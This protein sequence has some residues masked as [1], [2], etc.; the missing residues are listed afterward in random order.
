MKMKIFYLIYIFFLCL[1]F[2][3]VNHYYPWTTYDS[4]K[5]IFYVFLLI[6]FY[7]FIFNKKNIKINTNI[8]F[9]VI[10]F[11]FSISSYH[12][13]IFKQYYYVFNLYIVNLIV[14]SVILT[15]Y[16]NKKLKLLEVTVISLIISGLISSIF[17]I[18]QWIDFAKDAIWLYESDKS[19]LTAN[20]AQPNH[21]ATLLLLSLLSCLYVYERFKEN[22][23]LF[24]MPVIIF[25][26]VLT[27]SRAAFLTLIL[28]LFFCILKWRK[29]NNN[30]KLILISY[31]PIYI[32]VSYFLI[33]INEKKYIINRLNGG[34][35]RL[36]IWRDFFSVFSYIDIWGIG[37]KNI[38]YFQFQYGNHFSGYLSSYHN[39]LLDLIVIFGII[40]VLFFLYIFIQLIIILFKINKN[41]D[42][43][44]FLMLYTLINHSLLEFPLFYNYFLFVFCILYFYLNNAYLLDGIYIKINKNIFLL[45]VFLITTF[46]FSFIYFFEKERVN[47]RALFLGY[48]VNDIK[49]NIFF[50]EFYNLKIINC[51]ENIYKENL[52]KF[53]AGLLHRPSE[54][55]ILKLIYIY[56]KVEEYEKRNNLLIKYNYRYKKNYTVNEILK[57]KF[58]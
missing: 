31:L 17:S 45:I 23:V 2:L 52:S 25:S 6:I 42:F 50:D 11:I 22:M 43:I 1:A 41:D 7:F 49:N 35:E 14:L 19:R 58:Y 36:D 4:E 38:E 10:L 20:M 29:L 56:H 51:K 53:E 28:I 3:N 13:Y 21:L 24:L 18:Y 26:L 32:L 9:L 40:G 55:N 54:K 48:C 12:Y 30:I 37:W 15:N 16:H 5:N 44:V 46:S 39:L 47:Y 8:L 27:Q 34:F 33:K 57:I